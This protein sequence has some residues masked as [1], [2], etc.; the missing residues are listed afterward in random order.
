M[1]VSQVRSQ[2]ERKRKQ[3]LDAEKKLGEFRTKES[4][5]FSEAVKLRQ[6]ADKAASESTRKSRL[7]DVARAYLVTPWWVSGNAMVSIQ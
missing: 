7:R 3:R 4:S 2:L 6:Q 1:S 5:K